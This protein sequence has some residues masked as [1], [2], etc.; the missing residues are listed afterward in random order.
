LAAAVV[1]AAVPHN[2]AGVAVH[3]AGIVFNADDGNASIG[4]GALDEVLFAAAIDA[5]ES[6]VV[7]VPRS[8]HQ[9]LRL[10]RVA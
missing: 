5:G 7:R 6:E 1:A 8:D 3:A 9:R 4:I 10:V 2:V